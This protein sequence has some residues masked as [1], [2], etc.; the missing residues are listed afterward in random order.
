MRGDDRENRTRTCAQSRSTVEAEPADPQETGADDSHRQIEGGEIL[1]A[2][3]LSG[4]HHERRK[5][6]CDACIDMHDG[7][8]REIENA[9]GRE[10]TAA[11]DPMGRRDIDEEQ[12]EDREQE[13]C[14]K[15]EAI[16]HGACHERAGD[17]RE[18]HLIGGEEEFGNGLRERA[19]GFHP[20]PGEEGSPELPDPCAVAM[21][22]ER[23]TEGE[24][25]DRDDCGRGKALGHGCEHVFL[26]DHTRIEHCETGNGHHQDQRGR[27]DHE[28]RVSR[29]DCASVSGLR[30][31]GPGEERDRQAGAE[32]QL[33]HVPRF[34]SN[35]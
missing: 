9:H 24:P 3:A 8:A 34:R 2:V 11:P 27:R 23:V 22:T 33:F 10:E 31:N 7:A 29:A 5:E 1:F 16:G 26:A 25:K 13:K 21:E 6:T 19:D 15:P 4:P 12:P 20:D 28:S 14:R 32:C 30:A 35:D 18:C 17:H